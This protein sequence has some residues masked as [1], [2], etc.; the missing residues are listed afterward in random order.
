[1]IIQEITNDMAQQQN[2]EDL[3]AALAKLTVLRHL[4]MGRDSH[5]PTINSGPSGIKF[6]LYPPGETESHRR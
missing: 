3:W 5:I 1:M 4:R 2:V 6:F